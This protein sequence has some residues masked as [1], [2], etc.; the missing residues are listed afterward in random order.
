VAPKPGTP[1]AARRLVAPAIAAVSLAA[2]G[3][4]VYDKPGITY[5][6]YRRDDGECRAAARQGQGDAPDR[7]TYV[8]CM[9][10]RGYRISD[11]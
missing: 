2:C 1:S 6:E 5:A 8:R 3:T 4:A 10:D 11:R 7:A 9:R